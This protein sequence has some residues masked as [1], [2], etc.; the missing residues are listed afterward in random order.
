MARYTEKFCLYQGFAQRRLSAHVMLFVML[1]LAT[2]ISACGNDSDTVV[3]NTATDTSIEISGASLDGPI[4]NG[5]VRFY[6]QSGSLCF[7]TTTGPDAQYTISI[8]SSCLYPL[9]VELTGGTD[10]T[11]NEDNYTVMR[12][13]VSS[14]SATIVNISPLTTV[15]YYT[16]LAKSGRGTFASIA[17]INVQ[18]SIDVVL[19]K[20]GFGVDSQVVNPL[21]QPID[22]KNV[23]AYTKANEGLIELVRRTTQQ[24]SPGVIQ[25][26]GVNNLFQIIG[27]DLQDGI[28]N[29]QVGDKKIEDFEF[30]DLKMTTLTQAM[31][32]QG[33]Q[34]VSITLT[35]S[36]I[37]AAELVSNTLS[38][39]KEDGDSINSDEVFVNLGKAVTQ[40]TQYQTEVIEAAQATAEMKELKITT[41]QVKQAQESLTTA[42]SLVQLV[43][44]KLGS[45]DSNALQA[46][47]F[48]KDNFDA[49]E[50]SM[51]DGSTVE[52][53]NIL[54]ILED[55]TTYVSSAKEVVMTANSAI[56]ESNKGSSNLS[57]ADLETVIEETTD[58]ATDLNNPPTISRISDQSVEED[59][60]TSAIGFTIGDLETLAQNL[61]VTFNSS[62]TD[63]VP[64]DNIEA[65][66][67]GAERTL[68]ITPAANQNGTVDITIFVSDGVNTSSDT[69]ILTVLPIDDLPIV[70]AG[71]AQTIEENGTVTLSG[72]ASDIDSTI[73]SYLWS[74][75]SGTSVTLV[76][77]NRVSASFTAPVLSE[78][79]TLSFRLTITD[80]KGVTSF[81]E[82]SITVGLVIRSISIDDVTVNEGDS[83]SSNAYFPVSLDFMA[84]KTLSVDYETSSNGSI[85]VGSDYTYS[86]GTLTFIEGDTTNAIVVPILGDTLDEPNETFTMT[87]SNPVNATISDSSALGTIMDNDP[88]PTVSFTNDSQSAFEGTTVTVSLQL[89]EVSSLD[90]TIPIRVAGSAVEGK[91]YTSPTSTSDSIVADVS[92]LAGD[93]TA[94]LTFPIMADTTNDDGDT[95]KLTLATP[96]YADVGATN[97]HT[98][99]IQ[100]PFR[101]SSNTLRL[102]DGDGTFEDISSSVSDEV[103]TAN[104]SQGL[105]GTNVTLLANDSTLGVPPSFGF[106][107]SQITE[108]SGTT[109][110]EVLLKD[111]TNESRSDDQRQIEIIHNLTWSADGDVLTLTAI[112]D[113][114]VAVTWYMENSSESFSASLSNAVMDDLIITSAGIDPNTTEV[115][116]KISALKRWDGTIPQLSGISMFGDFFYKITFTN[117]PLEDESGNAFGAISGTFRVEP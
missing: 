98:I 91:D 96:T 69:F 26:D 101:L 43:N 32:V 31:N 38:V 49:I 16:A 12:S 100:N 8:P 74:Q 61:T 81:D 107:L 70:I 22:A 44:E 37:V 90:V 15:I 10:M 36:A 46:L 25:K 13:I 83:G 68:T 28:L 41:S 30:G 88:Q 54:A 73:A 52:V 79:E 2:L 4:A 5:T 115:R 24:I 59:E 45:I 67:A 18:K 9:G 48:L 66:G 78:E 23:L 55:I 106:T 21:T 95:I 39:T 63:L 82:V 6:N 1:L 114:P 71:S 89:S 51:G 80:E 77:A 20:F 105:D 33:S 35:Q 50:S 19:Q 11:T 75:V 87:L 108:G 92:I 58:A 7:E 3:T 102:T 60:V 72:S 42:I 112:A 56:V 17:M 85:T 34:L 109:S 65:G 14:R 104:A 53:A 103:L 86:R 27:V 116:A 94:T 97:V 40:V 84:G 29:G 99:T 64:Q 111:G 113:D 117:L 62:D 47:T 57:L 110:V 93:T 76:D